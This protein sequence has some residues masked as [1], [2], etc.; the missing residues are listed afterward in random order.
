MLLCFHVDNLFMQ[1]IS[2]LYH[3]YREFSVIKDFLW[4]LCPRCQQD[5]L[6]W[7]WTR[8]ARWWNVCSFF[9]WSQHQQCLWS[10]SGQGWGLYNCTGSCHTALLDDVDSPAALRVVYLAVSVRHLSISLQTGGRAALM[11]P[12]RCDM[13]CPVVGQ[14]VCQCV[15]AVQMTSYG[16]GDW[17]TQERLSSC[18]LGPMLSGQATYL[19]FMILVGWASENRLVRCFLVLQGGSQHYLTASCGQES[20]S[21]WAGQSCCFLKPLYAVV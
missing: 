21:V 6:H 10:F 18:F 3:F 14:S 4:A 11:G 19:R 15:R 13:S 20:K 16:L 8:W 9:S 1:Q 17:L 12:G 7:L 5:M 2:C